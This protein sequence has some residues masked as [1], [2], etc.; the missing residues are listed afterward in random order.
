MALTCNYTYTFKENYPLSW[1]LKYKIA[2]LRNKHSCSLKHQYFVS[3]LDQIKK[4]FFHSI[5]F[6]FEFY[7]KFILLISRATLHIILK[8]IKRQYRVCQSTQKCQKQ[9]KSWKKLVKFKI[10]SS[11][12]SIKMF[13]HS[14]N[15]L[16]CVSINLV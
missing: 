13:Q 9:R 10:M 11:I 3:R 1:D 12:W 4:K 7:S 6:Q 8:W 16:E 5:K 2:Q 14:K 15:Y